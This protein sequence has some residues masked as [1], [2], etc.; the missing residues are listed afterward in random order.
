MEKGVIIGMKNISKCC[1]GRIALEREL[2]VSVRKGSRVYKEIVRIKIV[3]NGVQNQPTLIRAGF[4]V[5]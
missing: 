1:L 4:K 3:W 5:Y 2:R